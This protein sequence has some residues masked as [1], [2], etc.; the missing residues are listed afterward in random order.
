MIESHSHTKSITLRFRLAVVIAAGV[1]LSACSPQDDAVVIFPIQKEPKLP[2]LVKVVAGASTYQL[3]FATGNN[4]T[5]VDAGIAARDLTPLTSRDRA[6]FE[7]NGEWFLDRTGFTGQIGYYDGVSM[8]REDWKI[9]SDKIIAALDYGPTAKLLGVQ[10]DGMLGAPAIATLNWIWDRQAGDVRGYLFDSV[11][12]AKKREKL[13]CVPMET[14]LSGAPGIQIVLGGQPVW[15]DLDTLVLGRL[16]GVLS[17]ADAIRLRQGGAVAAEVNY[18]PPGNGGSQASHSLLK[19]KPG[20]LANIAAEGLAFDE[21]MP[22]DSSKLGMVFLSKFEKA[23]FD[24][25][26]HRFCFPATTR[27]APDKFPTQAEVRQI[28]RAQSAR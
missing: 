12:F 27:L 4:A 18:S 20:S 24:F 17:Q 2:M 15:F 13:T 8:S 10:V 23:A 16:S 5:T 28:E 6:A 1:L 19:L 9:P 22:G 3:V 11:F 25:S 7:K 14:Q 21:A 26:D